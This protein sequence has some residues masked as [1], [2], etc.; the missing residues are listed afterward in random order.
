MRILNC[1]LENYKETEVKKITTEELDHLD[2]IIDK[3]FH[4]GMVWSLGC[5][6]N[7]E[8]RQKFNIFLK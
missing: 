5:T 2:Q 6:T 4:W 3:I 8:G 1:F 7:L